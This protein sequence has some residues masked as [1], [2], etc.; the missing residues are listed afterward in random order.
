M[1]ITIDYL[2]LTLLK[3]KRCSATTANFS[4]RSFKRSA[5]AWDTNAG[6]SAAASSKPSLFTENKIIKSLIYHEK[7]LYN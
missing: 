3:S 2:N 5:T 1:L 6:T 7:K 4:K